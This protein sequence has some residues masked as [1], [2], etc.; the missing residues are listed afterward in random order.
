MNEPTDKP[1]VLALASLAAILVGGDLARNGMT[2]HTPEGEQRYDKA[3]KDAL[4]LYV[5]AKK[6]LE[7][8]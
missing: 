3:V 6:I 8:K 4:G 2:Y 7:G 1:D 5:A